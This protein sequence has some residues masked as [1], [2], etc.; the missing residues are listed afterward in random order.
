MYGGCVA[1]II[2]VGGVNVGVDVGV[3]ANV[4]VALAGFVIVGLVAVCLLPML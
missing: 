1:A 2:A 4:I 3:V